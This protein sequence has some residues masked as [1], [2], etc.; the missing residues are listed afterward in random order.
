MRLRL[1]DRYF[2]HENRSDNQ[3]QRGVGSGILPAELSQV[4]SGFT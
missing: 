3:A 1:V 2:G 4:V